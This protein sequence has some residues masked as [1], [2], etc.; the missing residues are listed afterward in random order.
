MDRPKPL[1]ELPEDIEAQFE[2]FEADPETA[3]S[4]GMWKVDSLDRAN[5]AVARIGQHRGRLAEVERS[6]AAEQQRLADQSER[7]SAWLADETAQVD[8]SCRFLAAALE[9]YHQDRLDEDPKRKTIKLLAGELHARKQPDTWD[10]NVGEFIAW[11]EANGR[12]DLV[13]RPPAPDPRPDRLAVKKLFKVANQGAVDP[14]TG[15]VVDG[16]VVVIG[17]DKFTVETPEV[18]R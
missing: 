2:V 7:V 5:W 11:A 4:S 8:A 17:E 16:I 10:I 3:E 18:D 13:V 12:D 14:T 9:R 1:S 6:A 15:Q